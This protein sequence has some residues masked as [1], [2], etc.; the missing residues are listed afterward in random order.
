MIRIALPKGRLFEESIELFLKAGILQEK[1][2][3]GR[4][5]ILE[6]GN[7]QIFIVKPFDV[8]IYVERGIADIGICGKDVLLE[9]KNDVYE[10]LDLDIG[11]CIIAIASLPNFEKVYEKAYKLRVATKYEN[12]A[13]DFFR[14]KG[15]SIDIIKLSGSVEIA[16][17]IGLSD[18]IVD[19]VQTGK[20]LK[21]N[22][23]K[24]IDIV[25]SSSAYLIANKA[26]FR[27]KKSIILNI[28]EKLPI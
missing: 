23:L 24:I 27:N 6:S 10:L 5:L 15:V 25:D 1:I 9:E 2:D 13:S 8:G 12:I 22:G 18:C 3:E 17:L 16:P 28:I 14:K 4:K 7:F 21:E 20:T 11:K 19:L 26:S